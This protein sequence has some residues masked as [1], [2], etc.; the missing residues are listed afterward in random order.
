MK[1]DTNGRV[2]IRTCVACKK[3]A[4]QAELIRLVKTGDGLELDIARR[5]GGRGF[6]LHACSSCISLLAEPGRITRAFR[7]KLNR[8]KQQEL[9][10]RIHDRIFRRV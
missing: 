8:D 10:S 9:I 3:Q 5:L 2:P 6:Y 7:I 1:K 4:P